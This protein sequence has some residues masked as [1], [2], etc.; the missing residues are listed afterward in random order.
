MLHTRLLA[1]ACAGCKE[2]LRM[3]LTRHGSAV[4]PGQPFDD[5]PNADASFAARPVPPSAR[6]SGLLLPCV[7]ATE[8]SI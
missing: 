8:V 2:Q 4:W 1:C 5:L 6:V 3:R 7:G